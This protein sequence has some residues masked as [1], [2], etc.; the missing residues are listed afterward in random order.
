MYPSGTFS[1]A[2]SA[3]SAPVPSGLPTYDPQLGQHFAPGT[4]A[5][6]NGLGILTI[7]QD[8]TSQV[9]YAPNLTTAQKS[10]VSSYNY[11]V[12]NMSATGA[13]FAQD[14]PTGLDP[15]TDLPYTS[16]DQQ[17]LSA[18]PADTAAA[19]ALAMVPGRTG[20]AG[21]PMTGYDPTT[22]LF[23]QGGPGQIYDPSTGLFT[24]S[25]QGG[26]ST[27]GALGGIQPH[28][29]SGTAGASLSATDIFTQIQGLLSDWT[30][31]ARSDTPQQ[32][33][34][35][36][37]QLATLLGQFTTQ[38]PTLASSVLGANLSATITKMAGM[39][40]TQLGTFMPTLVNNL[41]PVVTKYVQ[42]NPS[43]ATSAVF[44]APAAGLNTGTPIT[45][46]GAPTQ[47]YDPTTGLLGGQT[48]N[49]PGTGNTGGNLLNMSPSNP[50][51]PPN[52]T[53][54]DQAGGL[55]STNASGTI[56]TAG[57]VS[58]AAMVSIDTW[59]N[60]VGLGAL[61][62]WIN[63]Q[64]TT[65]AGLGMGASD[66]AQ[67]INSTI[68]TA[69]GF[70]A[71]MPGYNQRIANG[72][73]NT[74]ANT[75]AGIA[76]YLGYRQ[77][78]R[79]MAETAGMVPGTISAQDIGNAWAGDVSTTELS[80][81]ITTEYTN[82]VNALPGVQSELQNYGF[83]AGLTPGQLASYY[84]NP[85]NTV[86]Q[87]QQQFNSAVI[88]GEGVLTGFGEIGKSQAYALQAFLSNQG[89]NNLG[90][91]QAANFFAGP[92]GSGLNSIAAMAQ[93]GFEAPQLGTAP[94]GPGVVNQG[95]LIG[96]GIGNT[97]D[98]LAVQRAAQTRSAPSKGGGG[99]AADQGGVPGAG[100]GA[101]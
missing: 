93:S 73:T 1:G 15:A 31:A 79:A 43:W 51:L 76:G 80:A 45:N 91:T 84:L 32:L 53:V 44:T 41:S 24:D 42:T 8:G 86:N 62:P 25:T 72:F 47:G 23:D 75:G 101:Q 49:N 6:P 89:Q 94:N 16:Q 18:I 63:A 92:L 21:A 64:V 81:R 65:L 27:S 37:Q 60:S 17:N 26:T 19:Q 40:A 67:T 12:F 71:L 55:V 83:T 96:A 77:Q 85:A 78:I 20:T 48:F 58:G 13:A 36:Q 98:L 5:L 10:T 11:V 33:Q 69:P 39:N 7:A 87:L 29:A 99:F 14:R 82:A 61:A 95:Q 68:N 56:S 70:D 50:L 38:Y 66:I 57:N 34:A 59:A 30:D 46:A 35:T 3:T 4:Y 90:S 52:T 54:V 74:D 22:G 97:P 28:F 100:Y 88:G 9:T 2:P